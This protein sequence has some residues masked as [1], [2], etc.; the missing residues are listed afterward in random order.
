MLKNETIIGN[1]IRTRRKTIALVITQ[2][3][4]LIVRAPLKTSLSYIEK[5]VDK[6]SEW[7]NRKIAEMRSRPKPEKRQ[8]IDGDKFFYLGQQYEL[9]RISGHSRVFIED[10]LYAPEGSAKHIQLVI[11]RWYKKRALLVISERCKLYTEIIG[12]EP[13]AVGITSAQKRWGSCG[14]KKKV[15]FSWRLIMAPIEIIDYV[16]AHELAHLEHLNH[17]KLFWDTVRSV[18]PDF[19]NRQKW[20]RENERLLRW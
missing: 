1:I 17:S 16:V 18:L 10:K 20:L 14:A 13:A 12:N 19:K 5:A 3:A 8:F 9:Q 4:E 15:N 7:I 6:R 11:E 2:D